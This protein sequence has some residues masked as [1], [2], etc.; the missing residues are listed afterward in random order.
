M[1]KLLIWVSIMLVVVVGGKFIYDSLDKGAYENSAST[2]VQGF[3][4]GIKQGGDFEEGFNMWLRG[5]TTGM[6]SISQDEYNMY[7][8]QL[9]AMLRERELPNRISSYEITGTTLI[10]GREGLEPAIVDVS[11]TIDG[12]PVVIH[13]VEGQPLSW[14]D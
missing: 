7:V 8:G 6:G 2:R 10:K 1:Q 3:L 5:S 11:C 12:K 9:N 14:A 13:A 4:D